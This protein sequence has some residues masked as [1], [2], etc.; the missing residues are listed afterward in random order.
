MSAH[1][2]GEVRRNIRRRKELLGEEQAI[3]HVIEE[4]GLR[5]CLRAKHRRHRSMVHDDVRR[6]KDVKTG[7]DYPIRQIELFLAE[8]E[9]FVITPCFREHI[10]ADGVSSSEKVRNLLVLVA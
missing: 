8:D 6:V 10:A 3:A 5:S 9:V 7:L 4:L 1:P 2:D